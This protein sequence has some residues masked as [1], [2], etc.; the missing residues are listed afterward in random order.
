MSGQ[1]HR[2]YPWDIN[3]LL[4]SVIR[5]PSIILVEQR[6]LESVWLRSIRLPRI[7][8]GG[9]PVCVVFPTLHRV[10]FS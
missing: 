2:K 10:A 7:H 5:D 3:S 8:A 4:L 9:S 6:K 1:I